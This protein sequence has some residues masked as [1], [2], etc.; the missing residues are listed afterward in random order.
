MVSGHRWAPLPV[1]YRVAS[2]VLPPAQPV[3]SLTADG[4]SAV[5]IGFDALAGAICLSWVVKEYCHQGYN[6]A[7][8]TKGSFQQNA[9]NLSLFKK[10]GL[11]KALGEI[12][13][14]EPKSYSAAR[15]D[16]VNLPRKFE[17]EIH[18]SSR[19]LR[20][21]LSVLGSYFSGA[22]N[23][24]YGSRQFATKSASPEEEEVVILV[25]G[26]IVHESCINLVIAIQQLVSE[27]RISSFTIHQET[28][29]PTKIDAGK[30]RR[31]RELTLTGE[32]NRRNQEIRSIKRPTKSKAEVT[33]VR[34]QLKN[35]SVD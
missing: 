34:K 3:Y 2:A 12:L 19:D 31:K 18:N 24:H 4:L 10:A 26:V 14:S 6:A 15:K 28:E 35:H 16:F 27:P 17:H 5:L 20:A 30:H 7:K 23:G 29:K 9:D 21:Q 22:T 33:I 13:V 8:V 32:D 1:S 11:P 25:K